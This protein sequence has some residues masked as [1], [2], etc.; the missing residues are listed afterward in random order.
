MIADAALVAERYGARTRCTTLRSEPPLTIRPTGDD[1]GATVHLIGSAA[2]PVGGDALRLSLVAEPHALL[3]VRS[4]AATLVLPGSSPDV[5]SQLDVCAR[6]RSGAHL[7]WLPEPTILVRGCDHR[8]TITLHVDSGATVLWRDVT[9]LGRTGEPSGSVLQR[10]RVDVAGRP[11]LR[12]D[13]AVGPRWPASLGPAGVGDAHAVGTAFVVGPDVPNLR[14]LPCPGVRVGL[15][16]LGRQAALV[17]ALG[18]EPGAVASAIDT[19]VA[20]AS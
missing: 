17:T 10:L 16:N 4:V 2:G 3:T 19:L 1:G 9:V 18:R 12:A 11:A 6:V 15:A 8:S 14:P 7:R 13:W 20:P 5:P